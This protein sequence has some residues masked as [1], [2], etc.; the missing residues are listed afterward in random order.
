MNAPFMSNLGEEERLKRQR[1]KNW[2]LAGA[3]MAIVVVIYVTFMIRAS[4]G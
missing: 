1:A 3:L 4:G 2:A